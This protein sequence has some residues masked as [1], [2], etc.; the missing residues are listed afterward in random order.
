[1]PLLPVR[2]HLTAVYRELGVAS[3]TQAVLGTSRRGLRAN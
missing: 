1:M 2:E 3:R